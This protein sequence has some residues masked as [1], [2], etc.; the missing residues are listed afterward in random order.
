MKGKKVITKV[1]PERIVILNRS[2]KEKGYHA[3][4]IWT[5]EK[6]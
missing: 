1:T 3:V 4:Q 2:F 5:P 6:K